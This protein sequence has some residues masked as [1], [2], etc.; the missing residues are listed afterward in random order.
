[1]NLLYLKYAIE[2]AACGSINKAAEK[3]YMDQP[4]LSRSIKELESSLGVSI[5]ERSPKGMK[6]TLEGEEFLKYANNILKQVDIAENMFKKGYE[7]KK[8]FS[9]SVPRASYIA[10]AFA[11][12]SNNL[13]NEKEFEIFYKETNALRAIK[14]VLEQNYQMGI[15]RYAEQFDKY[16]KEMLESKGL[17][18]ELITKFKY[19]LVMSKQ[20]PLAKL[21]EIGFSD[22][23]EH[24]EIA[25]ADP[26][27]PSL[28]LSEVKKE[29]LPD[30]DKRIYVFER[31]SQFE[32]LDENHETFMWVSLIPQKLLNRYGL[33]Q[34]EC[35]ENKKI[36]KDVLIYKKDYKLTDLDKAFITELCRVKRENFD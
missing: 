16:Y 1:M 10:E 14:N 35:Y 2:V 21:P 36:Y 6:V 30:M 7:D 19:N 27:V 25:H 26:Y 13:L 33:I 4:N 34:R 9:V 12:F 20:S 8:K 22:L 31:A 24:I 32:L 17:T 28:A 18:Y 29:E 11:S 3:L 5:F 23:R 15:I